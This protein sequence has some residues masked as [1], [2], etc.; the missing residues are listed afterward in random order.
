MPLP[1][2]CPECGIHN[3]P[4]NRWCDCG[5]DLD[6]LPQLMLARPALEQLP[7]PHQTG[8]KD[9]TLVGRGSQWEAGKN[10]VIKH[11]RGELSLGVSFWVSYLAINLGASLLLFKSLNHFFSETSLLQVQ[12]RVVFLYFAFFLLAP[13]Q[14]VGLWR[15]AQHEILAKKA[16]FW[17][18]SAQA[19]CVII[20][21]VLLWV[22]LSLFEWTGMA[23][24]DGA[25]SYTVTVTNYPE[26]ESGEILVN[27][28]VGPGIADRLENE[29]VRQPKVSVISLNV[30]GG[31]LSEAEKMAKSIEKRELSTYVGNQCD[32]A[33]TYAFI[34]G[35][36]RI[37]HPEAKLGFHSARL[38]G[39]DWFDPRKGHEND[40]WKI[41]LKRRGVRPK[42]IEK[43]FSVP[44]TEMWHPSLEELIQAR[45]VTHTYDGSQV[46][47]RRQNGA[48]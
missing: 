6:R 2:I 48:K 42:F 10:Y 38:V 32:S 25:Y 13:W 26:E 44:S 3:S 11:W 14:I 31:L 36:N 27:G 4:E 33:C 39:V 34:A 37:L 46:L 30:V 15:S 40:D 16:V 5:Y 1:V 47:D 28:F 7:K 41:F 24:H 29:L 23:F 45:V 35:S 20:T 21:A 22:S 12:L 17:P 9:A 43:A 8:D 19:I 18:R